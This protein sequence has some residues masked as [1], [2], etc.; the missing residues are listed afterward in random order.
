M[1]ELGKCAIYSVKNFPW[2]KTIDTIIENMYSSY[3]PE[4]LIKARGY[5]SY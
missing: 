3:G 2:I 5:S 1:L 4:G